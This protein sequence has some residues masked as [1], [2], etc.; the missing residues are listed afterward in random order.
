MASSSGRIAL[1]LGATGGIGGETA[2]ALARRGWRIRALVRDPKEAQARGGQDWDWLR[3]DALDAAAVAGAARGAEMIVHAVNP[4][5]YRN[6]G[7]LV[8][9][10]I[11]NSIGAA[12]ASGARILLPGTIYNYGP[13]AYPI[14]REDSPQHPRTRKGAIRVE[15]ERRLQAAAGG[16]VRSLVLRFG[17]FFGPKPGN[18]WFSQGLITPGQPVQY[19]RYP[20]RRGVGHAWAYLPDAGEAFAALVERDGLEP[21]ARFHFAGHWDQDGTAMTAA[22]GRA[23][24][25]SHLRVRPFPWL[26]MGLAAPFN[27]TVR[28]LIE[29]KP[30]WRSPVRLDNTRLV[31]ALGSE[32][33]TSLDEAVA[34]TLKGLGSVG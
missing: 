24:G 6:W 25:N 21:F 30:L 32:P 3:G 11:D 10:M 2:S 8:W 31:A 15:L 20:G 9:P 34:T 14:L 1:V 33:H 29:M 26:L 22:V 16:G 4:P 19:V 5:G 18:S 7:K 12:R 17:D 27:E 28:E 13:D 23:V